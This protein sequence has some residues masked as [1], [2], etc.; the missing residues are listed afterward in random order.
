MM[1]VQLPIYELLLTYLFIHISSKVNDV[2][3]PYSHVGLEFKC[4]VSR[5]QLECFVLRE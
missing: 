4:S 3:P 2:L 5:T 1:C